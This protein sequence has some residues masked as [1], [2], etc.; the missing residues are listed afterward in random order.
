MIAKY[1]ALSNFLIVAFRSTKVACFRAA[2]GDVDFTS[3]AKPLLGKLWIRCTLRCTLWCIIHLLSVSTSV[4]GQVNELDAQLDP[5][6]SFL[7]ENRL[8]RLL[9]THREVRSSGQTENGDKALEQLQRFYAAELFRP[10]DDDPWSESILTKAKFAL[11]THPNRKSQRLRLAVSHREIEVL[12][13]D[14]LRGAEVVAEDVDRT[15]EEINLIQRGVNQQVENLQRLTELKETVIGDQGRLN[16]L[17]QQFGHGEYLLGWGHFLKSTASG[18]NNRPILRDA[19]A[20]F[21]SYLGIE[22]YTNLTKFSADRFGAQSRFQIMATVGLAIVM[23]VI[24]SNQQADHCFEVAMQNASHGLHENPKS[25]AQWKFTSFLFGGNGDQAMTMLGQNS[26]LLRGHSLIDAI[27][28]HPEIGDELIAIALTQLAL[29]FEGDLLV[30]SLVDFPNAISKD[31]GVGLWIGGYLALNEFQKT[32]ESASL[33]LAIEKLNEAIK[34]FN[35]NTPAQICG[36]CRFLLGS[37]LYLSQRYQVATEEFLRASELLRT[38]PAFQELAAE[39]AY[40]AFKSV[41]LTP[42]DQNDN[43]RTIAESI[44][45]HFPASG[46]AKLAKFELEID[47]IS[48]STDQEIVD[49]L[50]MIRANA[51]SKLVR[52]AASVELAKRY[53]SI[54]NFPI[55]TFGDFVQSIDRDD[56]ITDQAQLQTYYYYVSTLI[57]RSNPLVFEKE[58]S[59]T[60]AKIK[61]LIEGSPIGRKRSETTKLLYFQILALRKS[62]PKN[63]SRVYEYFQ[64]L[65]SLKVSSTWTSAATI[66]IAKAFEGAEDFENID[67]QT[68]RNRMIEVY[69]LLL[70][71]TTSANEDTASFRLAQLYLDDGRLIEAEGLLANRE[72][73]PLWLSVQAELAARKN[74]SRESAKLWRQVEKQNP[75]GTAGWLDARL[76][77]VSVLHQFDERAAT[78][79]FKRTLALNPN[80]PRGYV[81]KFKQLADK[82]GVR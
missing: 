49:Y 11:A 62:Q 33:N 18:H 15:I 58:I 50:K 1:H 24:G 82:W 45:E 65:K 72:E 56:R 38:S 48:S 63:L 69:E 81:T 71:S 8:N 78:E 67:H 64:K 76:Q 16:Q 34:R 5:L 3:S 73:D 57:D 37:C 29:H 23:R 79:L 40:R 26:E 36:H 59:K 51:L 4:H 52:S 32:E 22:P 42:G 61:T 28:S 27:L 60:L 30:K 46:F 39:A 53:D 44:N 41:R 2:K 47:Q 54:A 31:D 17:R 80:M 19:E 35:T 6:E 12:Q 68:S 77:R 55:E 75:T 43:R 7:I 70:T 21:R 13:R 20:Y 74:D 25:I 9:L 14:Y 10:L 66:E